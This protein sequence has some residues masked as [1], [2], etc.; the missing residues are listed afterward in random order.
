MCAGQPV[1]R[2]LPS[3]SGGRKASQT[4]QAWPRTTAC[5][6]AQGRV[7]RPPSPAQRRAAHLS[8]AG[9]AMRRGAHRRHGVGGRE[10]AEVG[11]ALTNVG[12]VQLQGRRGEAGRRPGSPTHEPTP[13]DPHATPLRPARASPFPPTQGHPAPTHAN[14]R[15]VANTA[16]GR[17]S[18]ATT[19]KLQ[20]PP[21]HIRARR[22]QRLRPLRPAG[23]R[24]LPPRGSVPLETAGC[25]GR[26]W[27]LRV[28]PRRG[29]GGG[30]ARAA[31]G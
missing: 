9:A 31:V 14:P 19:L 26:Q 21:P 11:R 3:V 20:L 23:Q 10:R 28:R 2:W 4:S 24:P 6:G 13:S 8:A 25:R 17:R 30:P 12:G 18:T 27:R 7:T 5:R 16:D 29:G 15:A 22:L 1:E